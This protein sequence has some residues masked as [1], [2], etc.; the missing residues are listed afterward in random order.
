MVDEG[1]GASGERVAQTSGDDGRIAEFTLLTIR[2]RGCHDEDERARSLNARRSAASACARGAISRERKVIVMRKLSALFLASSLVL[3]ASAAQAQN[4]VD[5]P[6]DGRADREDTHKQFTATANPLSFGIGRYGADLQWLPAQHHA[7][8]FNPFFSSTTAHVDS[9]VNG[10]K[11][12]YDEKFSG[13]G[14][15]IGYRFYTG[16]RGANGFFV[17]PS[18]L[19][20]TYTAKAN[21]GDSVA[22]NS[23]GYAVDI[24]GQHV[25]SNGLTIGGGFGMQHTKVNKDFTD[26]PLTAAILAGG[27]WRPRF[28]LSLGYSFG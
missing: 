28:L 4:P 21:G 11:A 8:L 22:F 20:G 6:S 19:L 27:G 16:E 17:G 15:E 26:L 7:I 12:S 23:V 9:E 18:L 24:G 13:V 1:I 14:G 5:R 10:V 3:A 25:F 2:N